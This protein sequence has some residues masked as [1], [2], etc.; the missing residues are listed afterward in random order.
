MAVARKTCVYSRSIAYTV[1]VAVMKMIYLIEGVFG[2]CL[3]WGH[4]GFINTTH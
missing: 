1:F 3:N 4:V 2:V